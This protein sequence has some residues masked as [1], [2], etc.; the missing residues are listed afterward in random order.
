[1]LGTPPAFILS[2]DQTLMLKSFSSPEQSGFPSLFASQTFL[3]LTVLFGSILSNLICSLKFFLEFSG[4]HY[5][6]FVKVLCCALFSNNSDIL[7]CASNFVNNFFKLFSKTFWTLIQAFE[8]RGNLCFA[9][10]IFN[11]SY[12]SCLCQHVFELFFVRVFG[13]TKVLN[14]ALISFYQ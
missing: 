10:W 1:M 12:P 11:I 9:R 3:D 8:Y 4:L 13:K 2:Q 14:S 6:L 5:C 7:S